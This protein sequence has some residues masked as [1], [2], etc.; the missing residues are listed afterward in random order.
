MS[1]GGVGSTE[2]P[3]SAGAG[4]AG[5]GAGKLVL[6]QV[7]DLNRPFWDGCRAGELRLQ[8][9]D[10]G[11]LRY[12][13]ATLCP[14]CLSTE[15]TWEAVSGCGEVFSFA[16]FRHAYNNGWADRVPYTVAIVQLEEGPR[17]ISNVV[18]VSAEEVHV[19]LPLQVVFEAEGELAIPR[20]EVRR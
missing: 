13:I 11:H 4:L 1:A 6:P 5:D 20:F 17:M 12:P 10:R 16:V 8:R 18:G 7:D 19:G 3:K 15:A 2:P 14:V 9:C